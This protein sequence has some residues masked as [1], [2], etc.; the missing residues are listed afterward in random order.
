V[1]KGT[2]I[3]SE[4]VPKRP[5]RPPPYVVTTNAQKAMRHPHRLGEK[6]TELPLLCSPCRWQCFRI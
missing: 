6:K 2:L 1:A 3:I 5:G 4:V